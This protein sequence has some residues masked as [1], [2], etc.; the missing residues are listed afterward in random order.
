[1]YQKRGEIL[2]GLAAAGCT[3][4]LASGRV[5]GRSFTH[6]CLTTSNSRQI[7]ASAPPRLSLMRAR[8]RTFPVPSSRRVYP[9]HTCESCPHHPQVG[10]ESAWCSIAIVGKWLAAYVSQC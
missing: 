9:A 5:K 6:S 7:V 1:M 10:N 2:Y 8:S 3:R 4:I